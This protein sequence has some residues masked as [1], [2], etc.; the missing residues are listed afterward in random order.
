MTA[1]S[2]TVGQSSSCSLEVERAREYF[3]RKDFL[4]AYYAYK[5]ALS[6]LQK[7]GA[8]T[9]RQELFQIHNRMVVCLLTLSSDGKG[10]NIQENLE[11]AQKL[12]LRSEVYALDRDCKAWVLV[13][14]WCIAFRKAREDSSPRGRIDPATMAEFAD[15]LEKVK[16]KVI[17]LPDDGYP[18]DEQIE[19]IEDLRKNMLGIH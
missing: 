1:P 5:Q 8:S 17:C 9:S 4:N 3:D 13:M 12:S 7:P 19:S 2:V 16:S 10:F 6:N 14:Q 15:S 18:V 11:E